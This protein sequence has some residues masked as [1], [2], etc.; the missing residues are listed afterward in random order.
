M[1]YARVAAGTAPASPELKLID[2][3]VNDFLT[4][5]IE[6]LRELTV[7]RKTQ[8]GRFI[9]D[10]AKSLFRSLGYDENVG[11]LAA[12]EAL[13]K[14]L[15]SRMDHRTNPGLLICLSAADEARVIA[16]VLKLQVVAEHGAILERLDSGEEVLSAVT[17]MLDKPGDLQK[18][19]LITSA[20]ADGRVMTGDRLTHDAAYFPR[21]FGIQIYS[22]PVEGVGQLLAAVDNVAPQLVRQVASVL[23]SVQPGE[24]PA[25]LAAIGQ[26][27][28]ELTRDVQAD[29]AT[30]LS[31]GSRPVG[32]IDTTRRSIMTIKIG[33]ITVS[34]P[35]PSMRRFTRIDEVSR[36]GW[37]V[38]VEGTERPRTSYR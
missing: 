12:A 24:P 4:D 36:Q 23:P 8:P 11:F 1:T 28:P 19:A 9:D 29:V 33:D 18:G 35:T 17:K 10:S 6:D 27:V 25:V 30:A 7:G 22:R 20:L 31:G 2:D 15:I 37:Q 5:H 16:G 32:V 13:T 3:G 38:V 34:G 21:A 26:E 14:R